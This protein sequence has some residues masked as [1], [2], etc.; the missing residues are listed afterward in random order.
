MKTAL[1]PQKGNQN[2]QRLM[3]E[4]N[5]KI[6]TLLRFQINI[7]PENIV[8]IFQK[9]QYLQE[10]IRKLEKIFLKNLVSQNVIQ[11]G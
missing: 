8:D 3:I 10:D 11:T 7:K 9:V 2:Q 6:K 1:N 5:L 4:Q